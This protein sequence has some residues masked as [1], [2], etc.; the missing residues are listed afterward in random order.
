MWTPQDAPDVRGLRVRTSQGF[1]PQQN[2]EIIR[3][4][5]LSCGASS[6]EAFRLV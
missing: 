6:S 4:T 5:C 2:E 1:L 3:C